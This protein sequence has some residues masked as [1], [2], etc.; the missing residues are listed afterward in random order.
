MP[1][2]STTLAEEGAEIISFKLVSQGR[3]DQEGLYR[4]LV[5]E[6]AKYPG[7]SGCRNYRDVESDIKAVSTINRNLIID[8]LADLCS[9]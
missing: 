4:L 1:A 3:F 9:K 7:G 2:T 5:D 8:G 6:P